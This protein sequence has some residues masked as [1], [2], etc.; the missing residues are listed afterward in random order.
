MRDFAWNLRVFQLRFSPIVKKINTQKISAPRTIKKLR[1]D[2]EKHN[3]AKQTEYQ[4]DVA[5]TLAGI[6]HLSH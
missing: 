6:R 2:G 4:C 5:V 1:F 3:K